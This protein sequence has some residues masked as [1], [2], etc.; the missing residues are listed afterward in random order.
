[1]LLSTQL[2]IRDM[3]HPLFLGVAQSFRGQPWRTRLG[4]HDYRLAEAI[5][6][7]HGLPIM[8]A[9]V[10]ASRNI[11]IDQVDA[12][13]DPRLRDLM[14]DPSTLMDMD[15]AAH[16]LAKH[17]T[18]RNRIAIFGDYDV[19][20]A[21]ASALLGEFCKSMDAPFR[22]HIPDRITE[23]YG[24]NID[25]I[26][27][28]AADGAALLVC[29]DCGTTSHDT[30]AEAKSLG[31]DVIVLDHHQ[32]PVELP[33]ID[34]LVNPNRQDD[35]SGQGALCAAG[36]VFLT[37][38]AINRILRETGHAVPDLMPSLDLVAL[39]TVADVVPLTG[40]N[41]AFVT[42]GLKIMRQRRRLGLA[43]L[44]DAGRLNGPVQPYHLGFVLGP[45]INAGGRIGDAAL[46]SR[47]LLSEDEEEAARIAAQLDRLNSERQ[48]AEKIMVEEA[49]TAAEAEIGLGNAAPAALVL[50]SPTFH[51]GIV[52]LIASR[53]KDRFRRPAFAFALKEDGLAVGSGRSVA[54][55][56]L[57]KV[58]RAAVDAGLLLKGGG[59]G[60]A[61]GATMLP[62]RLTEFEAFLRDALASDVAAAEESSAVL[63]DAA[64][65]AGGATPEFFAALDR[66]GPFGQAAPEPVF[67]FS[68]HEIDDVQEIGEA[69]HIRLMLRAGD[70]KTIKGMAFRAG[71][72]DWGQRL[73]RSRGERLH[74]AATLSRDH[75]G[76]RETIDA[77]IIDAASVKQ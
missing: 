62:E 30:L 5:A 25:A 39:A 49:V 7:S 36:V 24:P 19:D 12:F 2:A 67:V 40:L 59:H 60:M 11:A 13:L 54:G 66:A 45:R 57:G 23:G 51:P 10:I 3:T 1:M 77:R 34:A 69:R 4:E 15:K 31:L 28:L 22:I 38:V 14:P 29:V 74:F 68:A 52:G 32:A 46:G 16:L 18:A 76:G 27:Q 21:C 63:I 37:L 72:D 9:R 6:Q 53:L 70:G 44:M 20:G 56:D 26:R 58:V 55:A 64:L 48:A 71:Q 42:Q 65:T 17:L 35:L 75:W 50:A 73:L 47:L 33:V 8:L 61:A 43:R 41:R